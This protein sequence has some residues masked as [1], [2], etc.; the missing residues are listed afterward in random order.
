MK[1]DPHR[2]PSWWRAYSFTLVTALMFVGSWGL[3]LLFQY[4]V[5]RD[6][7]AAHGQRFSWPQFWPQFW[8]STMENWQS[9]ALQLM[10]Q[11]AG[12]ALLYHWG[13]SQSREGS[14][15][16]EAK[17]DELLRRTPDRRLYREDSGDLS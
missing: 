17:V 9:E 10:W 8:A 15:R 12:L 5:V 1:L 16:L 4:H 7:A 6:D 2:R 11:A 13:S 14:D 3:Q